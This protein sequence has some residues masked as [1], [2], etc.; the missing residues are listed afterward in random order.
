[1]SAMI[2][3]LLV[4]FICSTDSLLTK[5]FHPSVNSIL[6]LQSHKDD[7]S[8]H[9]STS[10]PEP[11]NSNF[12]S[13]K[14]IKQFASSSLAAFL[15]TIQLTRNKSDIANADS[16]GPIVVLG[17]GGKTGK[18]IVDE[19][20]KNQVTVR[21]TYRKINANSISN[22]SYLLT[23]AAADVTKIDTI[24]PA[25]EGASTVIFAATASNKGIF[26]N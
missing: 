8:F 10:Q 17:S 23:P 6:R 13:K 12:N 24:G 26:N 4:L 25:I 20:V 2:L 15:S 14:K 7:S 5:P 22:N 1:M 11:T 16:A 21:P 3:L 19:L 18:L 9:P